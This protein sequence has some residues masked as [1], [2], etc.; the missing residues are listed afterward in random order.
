VIAVLALLAALL[1]SPAV[2]KPPEK[3][4]VSCRLTLSADMSLQ[5]RWFHC[6]GEMGIN[7][8][9][10]TS[11][12]RGQTFAAYVFFTH[13]TTRNDG[14][15]DVDYDLR[16]KKPSGALYRSE[17][18]LRGHMGA[19]GDDEHILLCDQVLDLAFAPDDAF[20]DYVVLVTLRDNAGLTIAKTEKTIKLVDYA[21]G[22]PIADAKAFDRWM[23][24]YSMAPEPLRAIPTLSALGHS[25]Y[26]KDAQLPS[27]STAFFAEIFQTNPWL[28]PRL[29]ERFDV[30]EPETK[31]LILWMLARSAFDAKTFV[32]ALH[33]A[34]KDT[35]LSFTSG[36]RRDP[37]LDPITKPAHVD[38]LWGMF[39]A[40]G[41]FAVVQ[42]LC[43]AL[44]PERTEAIGDVP[45]REA[46]KTAVATS[47]HARQ[48][49]SALVR[50]YCD[51]IISNDTTADGVRDALKKA[52]GR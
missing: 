35:W 42:R 32:A 5:D 45:E 18:L 21:D 22:P 13:W 8:P 48:R 36:P 9:E 50:G 44:A 4:G 15:V 11:I 41:K 7:L 28:F 23:R 2:P 24:G 49:D 17:E 39:D 29:L 19:V 47:L 33:G 31:R 3:A 38:E 43:E 40:G 6:P 27:S 26:W 30:Q 12:V 52:L 14:A 10:A 16:I 34:E 1:Q 51:W 46:L 25:G 20:G 37:L